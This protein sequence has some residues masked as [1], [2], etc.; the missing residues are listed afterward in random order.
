MMTIKITAFV[1]GISIFTCVQAQPV[2]SP[3]EIGVKM[4]KC[5]GIFAE[6][7]AVGT[8]LKLPQASLDGYMTG[9]KA[10]SGIAKA[11]IGQ[12]RMVQY[13]AA[14]QAK[15]TQAARA[16][17]PA[18]QVGEGLVP[19]VNDCSAYYKSHEAQIIKLVNNK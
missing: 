10:T 7:L 17:I 5:S 1:L 15:T 6:M 13:A 19:Q 18:M 12:D 3:D 2:L 9:V 14:E 4:A 8:V 11:L 16:G